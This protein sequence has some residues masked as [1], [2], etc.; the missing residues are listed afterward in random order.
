MKMQIH[1]MMHG[2]NQ[3]HNLIQGSIVLPSS[4]DMDCIATLSDWSEYVNTQDEA[5]Y[6]TIYPLENS[7]YYVISKTWYA[8]EMKRPGC[9]WTHSLLISY[10]QLSQIVDFRVFIDMFVRP[11]G[12]DFE[13]YAT[14]LQ[15]DPT[16]ESENL[17][18][19]NN[20]ILPSLPIIFNELINKRPQVFSIENKSRFYQYLCLLLMNYFPY[21]LLFQ[22]S[23]CTGSSGFR[24][25]H[26]NPFSLQFINTQHNSIKSIFYSDE[27]KLET[28]PSWIKLVAKEIASE[29]LQFSRML[30]A[31]ADDISSSSHNFNDFLFLIELINKNYETSE[32]KKKGM[33][34]IISTLATLFPH[35]EDGILLK[36][37][38]L[39][40]RIT[41]IFVS[42]YDFLYYMCI[43]EFIN[44]FSLKTIDF[45]QR[46]NDIAL[47]SDRQLYYQLLQELCQASN[48]NECGEN[49]LARSNGYLNTSDLNVIAE[50]DWSLFQS[51]VSACPELLNQNS[52][53][54]YSGNKIEDIL[55]II[56]T[57]RVSNVFS[58]WKELLF[59]ILNTKISVH[60]D[61]SNI[62]FQKD[63]NAV[64]YV[65]DYL[66]I[67]PEHS[68]PESI[69]R[70][71]QQE[72]LKIL[73]W[74]ETVSVLTPNVGLLII[75]S[76]QPTSNIV[77]S[78]D[79]KRWIAFSEL[80]E[81]SMP[82]KYYAYLYLLSFNWPNDIHA[83]QF[84]RISFYPLHKAASEGT[85]D[86]ELWRDISPYTE[87]LPIWLDWDRC[88]KLRKA[89]V[90]RI[91][92]SDLNKNFIEN[93]TPEKELNREL[94][95]IWEK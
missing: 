42:D 56:L 31:F 1:Q 8:D 34:L 66:N 4:E 47:S 30:H 11:Q 38:F 32:E 28:V 59:K 39:Q 35:S 95:K 43:S 84:M 92:K 63:D 14:P 57:P 9:V 83:I 49:I 17:L 21:K 24:T 5:D 65:L 61:L 51:L 29:K 88:K 10:H 40:K 93:F 2:Y 20:L 13:F 90:K 80:S 64:S 37:R 81:K 62:I 50:K 46:F 58:G 85:L 55:S 70:L 75:V 48:L 33:Q 77:Q 12:G 7:E 25:L 6:I 19:A 82:I 94:V 26:D 67:S 54:S 87:D 18:F 72:S 52:W 76:I 69:K 86:Y 79:I 41:N 78:K 44:S 73:S 27:L 74:M 3:G 68:I 45:W 36:E 22:L 60:A 89:V 23:F 15:I 71:C 53:I 16:L 91:K